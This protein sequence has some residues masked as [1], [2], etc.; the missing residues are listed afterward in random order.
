MPDQPQPAPRALDLED[1]RGALGE[2]TE[3]VTKTVQ[4]FLDRCPE[5]FLASDV[6]ES[7]V[8]V[9]SDEMTD[10]YRAKAE[11]DEY[12]A[13]LIA[14]GYLSDPM[15]GVATAGTGAPLPQEA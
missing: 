10:L 1:I 9:C 13:L 2:M 15:E 14:E 12:R 4:L 5:G 3:A 7:I 6:A 11:R 8:D